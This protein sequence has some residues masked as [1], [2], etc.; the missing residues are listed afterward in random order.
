MN[1][2]LINTEKSTVAVCGKR[3]GYLMIAPSTEV[4]NYDGLSP[5]VLRA[6]QAWAVILEKMGSPRAYWI[7]LSEV[8]R[9][10]H[11][12]L[13]PRWPEDTLKGIPLFE[14][15]E[16]T[17]QPDWTPELKKALQDWASAFDVEIIN[18]N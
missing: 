12:H 8:T 17:P 11:V 5:E 18:P 4:Q 14:A 10:L 7:I 3:G 9:H 15:R 16:E 6:A 13:Y 2:F 1:P